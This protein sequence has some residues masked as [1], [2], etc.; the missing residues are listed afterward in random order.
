MKLPG[1][2]HADLKKHEGPCFRDK[3]WR[4]RCANKPSWCKLPMNGS[5]GGDGG[6]FLVVL[7]G[8]MIQAHFLKSKVTEIKIRK[9]SKRGFPI[10]DFGCGAN[11]CFINGRKFDI[12]FLPCKL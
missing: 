3:D 5:F 7:L 1:L 12:S 9:E 10:I 4:E 6:R 8:L 2:E 11:C